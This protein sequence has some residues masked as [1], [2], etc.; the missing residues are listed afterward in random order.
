L[1]RVVEAIKYLGLKLAGKRHHRALRGA[2]PGGPAAV[3]CANL[4]CG[5]SLVLAV[6]PTRL[7]RDGARWRH[8]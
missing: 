7:L 4:D 6:A 2:E 3:D 1:Q 5:R 8:E